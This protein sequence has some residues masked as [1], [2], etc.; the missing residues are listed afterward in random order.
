LPPLDDDVVGGVLV[1]LVGVEAALVLEPLLLEPQ[2]AAATA[3]AAT[4]AR[5]AMRVPVR[6]IVISLIA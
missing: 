5:A 4:A 2:P 3:S 1:V 6:F